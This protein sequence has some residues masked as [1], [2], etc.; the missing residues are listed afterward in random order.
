MAG[1]VGVGE[2][3]SVA[4][5]VEDA[6]DE[7]VDVAVG[8]GVADAGGPSA[9]PDGAPQAASSSTTLVIRQAPTDLEAGGVAVP[10]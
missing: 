1:G 4:V 9:V 2:G 10:G 7:G 6:D 3:S 8:V 5:G